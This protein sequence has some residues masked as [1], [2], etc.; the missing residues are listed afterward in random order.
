MTDRLLK[1]AQSRGYLVAWGPLAALEPVRADLDE[2]RATGEIEPAFARE[3]L[4]FNFLAPGSA[5]GH[6]RILLVAMPRPAHFVSFIVGGRPVEAMLPPTY[7]RYRPVFED[8]RRDLAIHA[9]SGSTVQLIDAPLKAL[10]SRLGLVRYGRNNLAYAPQFG[11]YMQL[12]GY[13]TDAELALDAGW[14]PQEPNLLEECGSC[15]VCEA[16][17]P[18][19]AIGSER[20]LLHAER[21]LTL[22]NETAGAWPSWVPPSAHHCLIGCLRC[23]LHCPANPDLP[24]EDSGMTFSEEETGMLL[25]GGER[26]GPVWDRIR[27]KLETLGQPYQEA[28]IGRNLRAFLEARAAGR[29]VGQTAGSCEAAE[30]ARTG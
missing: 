30:A 19:G 1:W 24:R 23:Q 15:G 21:C 3:N 29:T 28:V 7:V 27:V 11:S 13:A 20:V 9:L 12:L 26:L 14:R 17:C 10:A 4:T 6:W 22:A 18:T 25:A 16:V 8:V 5:T 2:R